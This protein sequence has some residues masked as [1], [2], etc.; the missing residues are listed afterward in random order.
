MQ[1]KF[2]LLLFSAAL[3]MAMGLAHSPRGTNGTDSEPV[4]SWKLTFYSSQDCDPSSLLLTDIS[5][6]RIACAH[7]PTSTYSVKFGGNSAWVGY[8]YYEAKCG[9]TYKYVGSNETSCLI[10][11]GL[12]SYEVEDEGTL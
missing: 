11:D 6:K 7:S 10:V 2:L 4:P 8:L 12:S 9:G 5:D 1:F 3:Q